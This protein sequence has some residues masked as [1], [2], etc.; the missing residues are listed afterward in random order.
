MAA[1]VFG[2][3]E[4]VELLLEQPTVDLNVL[5]YY[6]RS[7]AHV[8]VEYSGKKCVKVLSRDPRV[9]WNAKDRNGETPI[10]I[11]LKNEDTEILKILLKTPGVDLGDIIKVK[12]ENDLLRKMLQKADETKERLLSSVPECPVS[13]ELKSSNA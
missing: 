5:D 1:L 12:E 4:I 9:N 7:V 10:M 13:L 6:G 8:A 11:A 3:H 2:H